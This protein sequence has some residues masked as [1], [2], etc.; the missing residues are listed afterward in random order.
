MSQS[1]TS[2]SGSGQR[3]S[4]LFS[5]FRQRLKAMDGSVSDRDPSV[6]EVWIKS[7]SPETWASASELKRGAQLHQQQG[8]TKVRLTGESAEDSRNVK[9]EFTQTN[10]W[11]SVTGVEE[12]SR[13]GEAKR[14]DIESLS[15]CP[16]TGELFS[17]RGHQL[18]GAGYRVDQRGG[19]TLL[20]K[21]ADEFILS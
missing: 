12:T 16:S 19:T 4:Q 20:D 17:E 15:F 5:T 18:D 10:N 13:P 21:L 2:L 8:L 6:G 7:S 14:T 11:L 3:Y 1:L 9:L